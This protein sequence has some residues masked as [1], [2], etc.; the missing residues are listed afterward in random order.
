MNNQD[1]L[2]MEEITKNFLDTLNLDEYLALSEDVDTIK[3]LIE[4]D[5]DNNKSVSLPPELDGC[6]FNYYNTED[7]ANY[8]ANRYNK[9]VHERIIYKY[10][11][12]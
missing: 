4:T 1:Y 10:T 6:I 9:R 2:K 12:F 3:I 5:F 8:L 7:L 11:L